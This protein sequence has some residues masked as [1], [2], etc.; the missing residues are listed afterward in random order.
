M[1]LDEF[2]YEYNL[3][4]IIYMHNKYINEN[5]NQTDQSESEEVITTNFSNIL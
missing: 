5:Y 4:Y 2:L 1:N 3:D